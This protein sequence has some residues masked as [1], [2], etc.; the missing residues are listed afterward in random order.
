MDKICLERFDS[1][2]YARYVCTS[3]YHCESKMGISY[4]S[5]K[6]RGC[7]SY[8]PKF[9]LV[10]IHRMVKSA[11]GLNVLKKIIDNPGTV[12]YNYYIHAKGY[13]DKEGYEKYI[14]TNDDD[15]GI[16]DKTIFFRAC[17][18]VKSGFGCTIPPVYRNYVCNF[19]ICDEVMNK[20][21]DDEIKEQYVRE[22]ER[23]VKWAEWENRSLEAILSEQHL[24]LR[25][26]LE[27]CIKVLQDIP[28]TIFE[29]PQLKE[30]S[31]FDTDEKEA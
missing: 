28:L 10:D 4:C 27:E 31:V 21:A 17:P 26:N 30:I 15:N 19:F 2:G 9:E 14:R 13:F 3:C 11:E 23:F 6:M 18:F 22:R 29:F 20:V 1:Y 25:N 24:N 5:I 8:F 12:V 16:R 7:C